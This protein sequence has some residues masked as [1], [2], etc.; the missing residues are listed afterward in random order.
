M[1]NSPQDLI[2]QQLK[3]R[4][5]LKQKVFDVTKFAFDE[6]KEVLSQMPGIFNPSLVGSDERLNLEYAD[7]GKFVV[8]LK[9]AGDVLAFNMHTNAFQ[10]DREHKAWELAYIK[11]N[12]ARA[13]CGVI[14]IYNFLSDSF[15][16]N[17][18]DD[19]GYLVARVFING[20]GHFFVEG[21]RQRSM[22]VSGFGSSII[23]R[24]AWLRIIETAMLYSLEFDLLVPPYDNMKIVSLAQMNDEIMKSRMRTGKRLGFGFNSDDVKQ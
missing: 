19:L 21:K 20:E 2:L 14:N 18:Q 8:K 15:L 24:E 7:M 12:V 17:R 3:T 22:G 4:A 10:F 9:V 11:E 16:Y 6:L 1:K 23:S 13:Y 5:L